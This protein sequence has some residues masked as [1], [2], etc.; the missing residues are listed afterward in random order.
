MYAAEWLC[1]SGLGEKEEEEAFRRLI[2]RWSP[3]CS[4]Q[5]RD[6]AEVGDSSGVAHGAEGG[7]E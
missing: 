4:D 7:G 2:S 5:L 6:T 3:S 1:W